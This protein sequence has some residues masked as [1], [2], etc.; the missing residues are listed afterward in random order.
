M[1]GYLLGFAWK[2]SKTIIRKPFDSRSRKP[3]KICR[4]VGEQYLM[5]F[6]DLYGVNMIVPEDA[7][8]ATALGSCLA[9]GQAD[10]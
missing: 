4:L 1:T 7:V 6:E 5:P 8:F 2:K 10:Q 9:E 3:H